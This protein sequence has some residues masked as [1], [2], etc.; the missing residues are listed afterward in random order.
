NSIIDLDSG[1]TISQP[2]NVNGNYSINFNGGAG[3]KLKKIDTRIQLSPN[4]NLRRYASVINSVKSYSKTFSPGLSAYISKSKE[5]KY[6]LSV[7]DQIS[8]NS[9]ITTQNDTKIQ[10][11]TNTLSFNGTV[12]YKKV[13]SVN[14][15]Y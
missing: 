9:N 15:D 12:Y 3:F 8:Y 2:I 10:Y 6:D 11:Y 1:K 5:K 13:W 7:N 14:T 4:F